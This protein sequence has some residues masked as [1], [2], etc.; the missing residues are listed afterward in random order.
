M[1]G[2]VGVAAT[3]HCLRTC[4]DWYN[5]FSFVFD[6]CNNGG[7]DFQ[8]VDKTSP[9][10][11]AQHDSES[12]LSLSSS[13]SRLPYLAQLI[14]MFSYLRGLYKSTLQALGFT[15]RQA[16]VAIL[17]LDNSGKSTL[18]TKLLTGKFR[19]CP[20][21]HRPSCETMQI[22]GLTLTTWDLGG[23]IAARQAQWHKYCG[24]AQ[25]ILFVV[26]AAEEKRIPEAA[27]ELHELCSS[28]DLTMCPIAVFA[29]KSEVEVR[30]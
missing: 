6:H 17:G 20:P 27:K 29:N 13:S 3:N 30:Y 15:T 12:H 23:H 5:Y 18:Q 28:I 26:D 9:R 24:T 16:T 14:S 22:G 21:T 19:N 8:C 10:I 2:R 1:D 7:L 25:G 4:F 11:F